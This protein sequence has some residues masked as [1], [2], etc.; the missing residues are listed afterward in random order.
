MISFLMFGTR[1]KKWAGQKNEPSFE[2]LSF[3]WNTLWMQILQKQR[4]KGM[5]LNWMQYTYCLSAFAKTFI[6]SVTLCLGQLSEDP[7]QTQLKWRYY[8][9]GPEVDGDMAA[10]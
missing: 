7:Y 10:R 8:V 6:L 2:I 9:H 5:K 1:L 4:L 3:L